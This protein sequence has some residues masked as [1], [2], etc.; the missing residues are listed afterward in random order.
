MDRIRDIRSSEKVF[1]RQ[2][3]DLFATSVDYNSKSNEAKSFFATVQNKMHFAIHNH[4]ASELIYNRVDSDKEFMGLSTFKGELP[5]LNEAKI[6]KNYLT[7]KE[8]KGLNQLVSGYLDFAERQAEKEVTMTMKDWIEAL[9]N[10]IIAHKRKVLIG[11][12][13]ISHK[14]AIEKAEKE[15]AIYRKREMDLLESDFDR[16]IKKLKNNDGNSSK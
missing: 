10:Q 12:G 6:A 1:Y 15:F 11:K 7:E 4:T 9:D 8:L 14:Q 13:N 16:E 3:L 2:V 5:T